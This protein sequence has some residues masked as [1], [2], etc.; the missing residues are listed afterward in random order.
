MCQVSV[1]NYAKY[2]YLGDKLAGQKF[3]P[4]T[5]LLVGLQRLP[6][7]AYSWSRSIMAIHQ[8]AVLTMA[9]TTTT[10]SSFPGA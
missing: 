8:V 1:L 9:T 5:S 10:P 2:Y 4:V 3:T 7:T 6:S